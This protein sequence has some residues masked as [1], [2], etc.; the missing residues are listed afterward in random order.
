MRSCIYIH[1]KIKR[2]GSKVTLTRLTNFYCFQMSDFW[3]QRLLLP[4]KYSLLR[5]RSNLCTNHECYRLR[6]FVRFFGSQQSLSLDKYSSLF[7]NRTEKQ[8]KTFHHFDGNKRDLIHSYAWDCN[9]KRLI[10]I[11]GC[12]KYSNSD[13]LQFSI[14]GNNCL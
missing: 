11:V 8:R 12:T 10:P 3:S 5:K 13:L 9:K 7:V 14:C 1:L 6:M 4:D 2:V